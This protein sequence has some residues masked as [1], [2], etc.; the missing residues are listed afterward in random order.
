MSSHIIEEVVFTNIVKLKLPTIMRIHLVVNL[1]QVVKHR[2]LVRKQRVEEPKLVE[3]D[4]E[5][6]WKVKRILNKWK[7]RG[8][9]KYLVCWKEFTVEYDI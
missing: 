7:V 5:E 1:S 4:G 6:E 2:K 3:V 9:T 8:V